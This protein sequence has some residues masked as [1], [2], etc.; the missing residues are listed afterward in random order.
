MIKILLSWVV[1]VLKMEQ[2]SK[3]D[4]EL[5]QPLNALYRRKLHLG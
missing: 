4:Q 1:I 3:Y 2:L 5:C